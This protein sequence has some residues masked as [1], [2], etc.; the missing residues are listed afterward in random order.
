MRKWF[1]V[2]VSLSLMS[3]LT[4]VSGR[5]FMITSASTGTVC[6]VFSG[7]SW[8]FMTVFIAPLYLL[9]RWLEYSSHIGD[10]GGLKYQ[11]I[12]SSESSLVIRSSLSDF[13][14]SDKVRSVVQTHC[15][16]VASSSAK[17][18][19]A[20]IKESV[21]KSPASFKWTELVVRHVNKHPHL[22]SMTLPLLTFIGLK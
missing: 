10:E 6:S 4:P 3:S 15:L 5:L 20:M 12:P 17:S 21:V 1:G 18:S 7:R 13:Q 22:F 19:Q 14:A 2:S 9:D 16:T 11:V 8:S